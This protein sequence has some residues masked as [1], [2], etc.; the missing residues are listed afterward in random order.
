MNNKAVVLLSG[1]L[2]STTVLAYAC[3]KN[4]E[5]YAISFDYGQK[6][7]YELEKSAIIAKEYQ[8]KEHKKV[9]IDLS[10]FSGSS[11]T[12]DIEVEKNRSL[13]DIGEGIPLTYVPARNTIFLAYA[14]GLADSISATDIFI[15]VNAVDTSGYPDCRPEFIKAFQN[16]ANLA[17]RVGVENKDKIKIHAPLQNLNKAEIIKLGLSLNVNYSLTNTCYD[18]SPE[19]IACGTCDACI[20]RKN[21]F[22]EVG[23][24]DPIEYI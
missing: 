17:T 7:K 16:L 21:G 1:G 9:K 13:E 2:D 6:N 10:I 24:K 3:N 11:L 15:G 19:G 18:P 23:I 22:A 8:V 4:F 12:S 5:I 20:L 14:L